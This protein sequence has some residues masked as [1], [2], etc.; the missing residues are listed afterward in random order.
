MAG[1]LCAR[2]WVCVC[3]CMS[4]QNSLPSR[5]SMPSGRALQTAMPRHN[6]GESQGQASEQIPKQRKVKGTDLH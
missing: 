3:V 2:A 6:L 5:L 4:D 1:C